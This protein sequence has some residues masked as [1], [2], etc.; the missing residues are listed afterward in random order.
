MACEERRPKLAQLRVSG[1]RA[2]HA[3]LPTSSEAVESDSEEN[4]EYAALKEG[5]AWK[6]TSFGSKFLRKKSA[7]FSLTTGT[8]PKEEGQVP[9]PGLHRPDCEN[10]DL[11]EMPVKTP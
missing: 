11:W 8:R 4:T 2:G 1:M 5:G 3:G 6:S 7:S 9:N 10:E